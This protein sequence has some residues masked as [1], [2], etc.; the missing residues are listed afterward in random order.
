MNRKKL[1]EIRKDL[2]S[3]PYE[4]RHWAA[5]TFIELIDALLE[6][7]HCNHAESDTT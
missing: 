7:Q 3:T 5:N 1:V 2:E 6:C 4:R